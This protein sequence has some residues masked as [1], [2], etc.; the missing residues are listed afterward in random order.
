MGVRIGPSRI[1]DEMGTH[2]PGEVI[3]NPSPALLELA[4]AKVR[5]PETKQLLVEL[6]SDAKT[7]E[8]VAAP[9]ETA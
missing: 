2:D 5:D 6:L 4:A 3:A 8:A 1:A 7:A 9:E